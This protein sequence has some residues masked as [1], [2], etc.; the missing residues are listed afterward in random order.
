LRAFS[1]IITRYACSTTSFAKPIEVKS[2]QVVILPFR[3][4]FGS[5]SYEREGSLFSIKADA[6]FFSM[7]E[8][9]AD[10][11]GRSGWTQAYRSKGT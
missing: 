9:V 8:I 1:L 6:N 10:L 2:D 4:G 7:A 11:R 3:G 5:G